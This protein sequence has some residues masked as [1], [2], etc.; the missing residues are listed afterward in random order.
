M[1]VSMGGL[2]CQLV[3]ALESVPAVLATLAVELRLPVRVFCLDRTSHACN[4]GSAYV[5]DEENHLVRVTVSA[6]G[7]GH[8]PSLLS[9]DICHWL[10]HETGAAC[11]AFV[12]PHTR[13]LQALGELLK[14]LSSVPLGLFWAKLV[15]NRFC[16]DL[17]LR[18]FVDLGEWGSCLD[19]SQHST[20]LYT[21]PKTRSARVR[22]MGFTNSLSQLRASDAGCVGLSETR[23]ATV[24]IPLYAETVIATA[25]DLT[26]TVP[27]HDCSGFFSEC[28]CASVL[29]CECVSVCVCVRVC[30]RV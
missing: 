18:D 25:Q 23:S 2:P 13:S 27:D 1:R 28:Q 8:L 29:V 14:P 30:V 15:W 21:S 5:Y 6:S 17:Y 3:G 16:R 24:I 11:F 22:V 9:L 12:A 20:F 10:A 26:T 4:V 7:E 19:P